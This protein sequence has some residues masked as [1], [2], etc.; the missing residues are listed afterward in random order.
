MS[1][2]VCQRIG[3]HWVISVLQCPMGIRN[4][5]M[6]LGVR[7]WNRLRIRFLVHR[8]QAVML[9]VR[10]LSHGVSITRMVRTMTMAMAMA[11]AMAMTMAMTMT[12]IV[13]NTIMDSPF[14]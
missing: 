10:H 5:G 12:I 13:H 2:R 8:L 7:G 3:F 11:M 4:V 1:H 9:K 6:S 14:Q